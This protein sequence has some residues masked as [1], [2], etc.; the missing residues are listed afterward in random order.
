MDDT[1]ATVAEWIATGA[2]SLTPP[3]DS[4]WELRCYIRD[5]DGYLIEVRQAT[6]LLKRI[7]SD[8][9]AE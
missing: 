1:E 7:P 9:K 5:P 6:G 8:K 4:G 2:E 3:I